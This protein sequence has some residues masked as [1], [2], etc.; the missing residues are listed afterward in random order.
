[1]LLLLLVLLHA[2]A[3]AAVSCC[4]TLL[5]LLLALTFPYDLDQ[6][7]AEVFLPSQIQFD[8]V[9]HAYIEGLHSPGGK[10]C[11]AVAVSCGHVKSVVHVI[12]FKPEKRVETGR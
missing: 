2:G 3:G 4:S 6:L 9:A 12:G 5:L 10:R 1:M 7:V 11:R 8:C